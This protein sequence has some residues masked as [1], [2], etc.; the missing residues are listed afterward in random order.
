MIM[1]FLW[2]AA[3]LGIL[4][5][6][7]T[8]YAAVG[9]SIQ[10]PTNTTYSSSSRPLNYTLS[11]TS[12]QSTQNYSA[13]GC[14]YIL[15]GNPVSLPTCANATLS[16]ATGTNI[17][18][19]SA[20]FY[21]GTSTITNGSAVNFTVVFNFSTAPGALAFTLPFQT[22][23][24]EDT[25]V[26]DFP[27]SGSTSCFN[28][29]GVLANAS[30]LYPTRNWGDNET[31]LTYAYCSGAISPLDVQS[32]WK[33]NLSNIP[34][35]N[36]DYISNLNFI[37][38]DTG[39]CGVANRTLYFV[40]DSGSWNESNVTFN[41]KPPILQLGAA[42]V[43]FSPIGGGVSGQNLAFAATD[44]LYDPTFIMSLYNSS[45]ITM[46]FNKDLTTL[47]TNHYDSATSKEGN[48]V[49]TAYLNGT[50]TNYVTGGISY[51]RFSI[52]NPNFYWN[53]ESLSFDTTG[54]QS[55]GS[56]SSFPEA[57]IVYQTDSGPGTAN[58][59]KTIGSVTGA[60]VGSPDS[61]L[62]NTLDTVDCRNRPDYV[63]NFVTN[64]N[65]RVLGKFDIY[66]FNLSS[67]HGGKPFYAAMK[68]T[69]VVSTGLIYPARIIEFYWAMYGGDYIGFGNFIRTPTSSVISPLQ[70]VTVTWTTTQP[71]TTGYQ[72]YEVINNVQQPLVQF[73][74]T[75][76]SLTHT[77]T[78]PASN[79]LPD[80]V[81]H[82]S[83]YGTTGAGS[84]VPSSHEEVFNV[85][86]G[87]SGQ[88]LQG[89]LLDLINP[90]NGG[91]GG[92]GVSIFDENTFPI[93][94]YVSLDGRPYVTAP[95]VECPNC[96][97]TVTFGDGTNF[98][99]YKPWVS[100]AQ[101]TPDLATIGTHTIRITDFGGFR[102]RTYTFN[103]PY[104][105]YSLPIHAYPTGCIPYDFH[106]A[107]GP[108][109][110]QMG[111]LNFSSYG[112]PTPTGEFCSYNPTECQLFNYSDG[113]CSQ[114]ARHVSVDTG[115][116]IGGWVHYLCFNSVNS[117]YY[118]STVSGGVII[119]GTG[120]TGQQ[121][122]SVIPSL[123]SPLEQLLGLTTEQILA[124]LSLI[125][126]TAIGIF[127]G[128]KTKDGMVAVV[129]IVVMLLL[130]TLI[131]WLPFWVTFVIA[132]IAAFLVARFAR[133]FFIGGGGH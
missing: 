24:T 104:I 16:A 93:G 133:G 119:P 95:R 57:E 107:Q 22:L 74:D 79:V 96:T 49:F 45:A 27:P 100:M 105:P 103:L 54:S 39:S 47:C 46:A 68:V 73:Q 116:T 60:Y 124:M 87:T 48:P 52:F 78:V 110:D 131:Q 67:L 81:F 12:P 43:Y 51:P 101:F 3:C 109:Q 91:S 130:F 44:I 80:G 97:W 28:P 102:N 70:N 99:V 15:N 126:S 88:G 13:I 25:F 1:K 31:I 21:N 112:P 62:S 11:I 114:M 6:A 55:S 23:A 30:V 94:G 5:F 66:C 71:T 69:N 84:T 33:F 40:L 17:L 8:S 53:F 89:A 41:T 38:H 61:S 37:I 75:A 19:V 128:A 127:A 106:T 26:S 56:S 34:G 29:W 90:L 108:C 111:R 36:S 123:T 32:M 65:T 7:A 63:S 10:Q 9:L 77:M 59:L 122:G 64:V 20:T 115:Q 18:S 2:V 113:T 129:V 117:G 82:I 14:S 4:L 118:N 58:Y 132:I 120:G 42:G 83:F 76:F 98:T 92:L 85:S 121:G 125:I 50:I 72:F 35:N 86:S